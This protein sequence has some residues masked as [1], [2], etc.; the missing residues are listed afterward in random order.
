MNDRSIPDPSTKTAP[1]WGLLAGFAGSLCCLGPSAA[2][3]LGLGSSSMLFSMQFNQRWTLLVSGI[4]L[5]AG[6]VRV[7]RR[8]QAPTICHRSRWQQPVMM[9]ATFVL[10]YGLLGGLLPRLA[11]QAEEPNTAPQVVAAVAKQ[12][13]A[14]RPVAPTPALQRLTLIVEK[15][16]CPPCAAKIRNRLQG[17][18]AVR[19]L[20]ADAYNEE[21]IITYDPRQITGDALIKLIPT[22]YGVT[23]IRDEPVQ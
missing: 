4:L 6:M 3:L 13:I 20:R 15:M 18:P 5:L 10:A 22:Q 8:V 11:A 17:K 21:V 9:L 23:F 7:L 19:E 12:N 14:E 16:N 2:M 1:A